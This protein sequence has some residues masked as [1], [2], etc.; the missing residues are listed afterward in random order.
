M[1]L[2]FVCSILASVV[3]VSTHLI[4]LFDGCLFFVFVSNI[5]VLAQEIFLC[6]NSGFLGE[7]NVFL[8]QG[9]MQT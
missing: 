1:F 6:I 5:T 2:A 9:R 4:S 7:S 3:K 8:K